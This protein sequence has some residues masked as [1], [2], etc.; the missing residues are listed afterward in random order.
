[1]K[2]NRRRLPIPQHEF[3]FTRQAFNLFGVG[4]VKRGPVERFTGRRWNAAEWNRLELAKSGPIPS[5]CVGGTLSGDSSAVNGSRA[6]L[7]SLICEHRASSFGRSFPGPLRLGKGE[8]TR[9]TGLSDVGQG[10]NFL[11][12]GGLLMLG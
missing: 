11:G 5:R 12:N 10:G 9:A 6:G 7:Y 3:L 2:R 1:M 8:I 4:W